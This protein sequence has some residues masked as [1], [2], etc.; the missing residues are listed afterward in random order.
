MHLALFA[1]GLVAMTAA[2]PILWKGELMTDPGPVDPSMS[3]MSNAKRSQ[4]TKEGWYGSY[5]P[6]RE[7]GKYENYPKGTQKEAEEGDSTGMAFN[8]DMDPNMAME[9]EEKD[10][11]KRGQAAD[12]SY[13]SYTPYT[14]YGAYYGKY[15]PY[16]AE[17]DEEAAK[18]EAEANMNM[19]N[20][21]KDL[22][23]RGQAADTSYQSYTPYTSY[24]AYYTEYNPYPAEVD[25]EAAKMEAEA[26][27]NMENE[28]GKDAMMKRT[29]MYGKYDPYQ[30]YNPYPEAA[31]A[32]AASMQAEDGVEK[33]TTKYGKYNP[34]GKYENYEKYPNSAEAEAAKLDKRHNMAMPMPKEMTME[35]EAMST[36]EKIEKRNDDFAWYPSYK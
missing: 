30:A 9:D 28:E 12:T 20:E 7:Y 4:M 29:T 33:R 34:Y 31:D 6:Y 26:S 35:K 25:A 16:S 13:Q 17:V 14:S 19:E 2:A 3:Q 11:S 18:M 27:I 1:A 8:M 22:S 24:G 5:R 23:K 10:I 32:E 36:E 15:T 21:E